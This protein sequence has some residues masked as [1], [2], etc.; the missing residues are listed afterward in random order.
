MEDLKFLQ[1]TQLTEHLSNNLV[2]N[3]GGT[4]TMGDSSN[5]GSLSFGTA[6]LY[7]DTTTTVDSN[8]TISQLVGNFVLP[9]M[10]VAL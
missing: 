9:K 4:V 1:T 3:N 8:V 6:T 2:F 5:N 7:A 10:V